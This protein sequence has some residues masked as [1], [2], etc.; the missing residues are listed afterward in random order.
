M[1]L[2]G[3]ISFDLNPMSIFSYPVELGLTTGFINPRYRYAGA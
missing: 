3:L 1:M 2:G